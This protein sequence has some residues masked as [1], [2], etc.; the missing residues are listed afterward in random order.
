MHERLC[1]VSL[2]VPYRTLRKCG[3]NEKKWNMQ[4]FFHKYTHFQT[5]H[6]HYQTKFILISS[7]TWSGTGF[8]ADVKK[9]GAILDVRC[10]ITSYHG[11]LKKKKWAD[12]M[13][14]VFH[15]E[16]TDKQAFELQL[17]PFKFLAYSEVCTNIHHWLV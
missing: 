8:Y 13:V 2:T 1:L 6:T 10:I 4:I 9:Q 3:K 5:Q 7:E 12:D 15:Q 16:G 11:F 14:A 17:V